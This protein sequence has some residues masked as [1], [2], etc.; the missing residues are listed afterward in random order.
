M[1]RSYALV[2]GL[3][4][5]TVPLVG[6]VDEPRQDQSGTDGPN[7]TDDTS[8]DSDRPDDEGETSV[9][10]E[11]CSKDPGPGTGVSLP[12][13]PTGS[14][15]GL[16][17]GGIDVTAR[18]GSGQ[19]VY[20]VKPGPRELSEKVF[21]KPEEP[22]STGQ[23]QREAAKGPIDDLLS[24]VPFLVG[25]PEDARTVQEDGSM[26]LEEPTLYS[27]KASVTSGKFQVTYQDRQPYDVNGPPGQTDDTVELSTS[28][29]DPRDNVYRIEVDHVVQPPIPGYRTQGGVMTNSFHHG[30]T[31]SGSPLMPQAFTYGAFWAIGNVYINGELVNENRVVHFM[32]TQTVRDK[33]YELALDEELPLDEENTPAGQ[34]H[35]THGVVLPIQGTPDG[36]VHAPLGTCVK[37][38]EDATQPFIHLMF[39]NDEILEGPFKDQAPQGLDVSVEQ[40]ASENSLTYWVTPGKRALDPQVFGTAENPR[41]TG[42]WAMD[43]ARKLADE[44]KLPP[45]IP[46]M[47]E[48]LPPMVGAPETIREPAPDGSERS[49]IPTLFSENA[50]VT[51]GELDVTYKDR[52]RWDTGGPP[53]KTQDR[54]DVDATF[55]D[56]EGNDYMVEFNHTVK[57]PIPGYETGGGVLTNARHHG[58]TGTGSPMMPQTYTYGAFWALSDLHVRNETTDGEFVEVDRNVVTHFMTTQTLRDADYDI[59]FDRDLPLDPSNTPT[60]KIHHTHGVLFPIKAQPGGPV[61]EPVNTSFTLPNGQTQPFVHAMWETEELTEGPFQDWTPP[62]RSDDSRGEGQGDADRVIRISGNLDGFNRSRLEA[63]QGETLRVVFQNTGNTAHNFG[64]DFDGDGETQDDVKTETIQDGD[65]TS[66]TF[67]AVE[68]GEFDF[69]CSVTGHGDSMNGVFAVE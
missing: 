33:S 40:Q 32:T 8:E 53:G 2:L 19:T 68:S 4:L 15:S 36:P 46:G 56:P 22:R 23:W 44:G 25:V 34:E 57:P 62:E 10:P 12:P 17:S 63:E 49:S 14:G 30:Q 58:S 47:L 29:T 67:T 52:Q 48:D 59:V 38:G 50:K 60:G 21:G 3:L 41:M 42:S 66:V 13:A 54:A 69:F 35:H 1:R 55:T 9:R 37:T 51:S 64:I 11:A 7:E 6:C 20:W 18:Q 16:M 61:H 27:D 45:S 5:V 31:G 28:F 43:A 65:E 24:D 26:I 39:E